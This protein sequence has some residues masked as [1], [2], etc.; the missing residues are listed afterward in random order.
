MN[1]KEYS[2][3]L[4]LNFI[5]T[6]LYFLFSVPLKFIF[7]KELCLLFY[8]DGIGIVQIIDNDVAHGWQIPY[9]EI[10]FLIFL[11]LAY[12]VG[13]MHISIFL[14]LVFIYFFKAD[15]ERY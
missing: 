8:T 6:L 4:W 2:Y 13:L 14:T 15:I 3:P 1:D 10:L 5:E 9:H 12:G 7:K 11:C